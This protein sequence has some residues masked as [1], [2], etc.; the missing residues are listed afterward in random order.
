MQQILKTVKKFLANKSGNFAVTASLIA[1]PL[2]ASGGYAIDYTIMNQQY[3][4]LQDAADA[5]ALA[6]VKELSL[7]GTNE[8][9]IQNVSESYVNTAFS[10]SDMISG[11]N[12]SLQIDTDTD[13]TEGSVTVNLSYTW[14]P[15][16]AHYFDNRVTPI[17]VSAKAG[18]AGKKLTC[19]IGLMQ[20]Q[21]RAKS[22]I[23][24][25]NNAILRAD[26]C[27]V[28]SN[29]VSRYGLRADDRAEMTAGVIC[30]AGGVL[31]LGW[32]A[33][34]QFTPD[35]ITDCPKIPDPLAS[36]VMPGYSG[37]NNQNSVISS[38]ATLS[39]GV[40]CGGLTINGS[41]VANLSPGI[42]VIKDGPLAIRDSA[43]LIGRGI[44]FFLTGSN[45]LINFEAGST[46]DLGAAETGST[47]G[48]LFFEDRG[49]PHSFDFDP[50]RL[51]SL[52]SDVRL[53]RISSNNARNLLGTIYLSKS[54][55]LIDA[56]APVADA[57]AYTAIITGRLWLQQGPILTINADY[58]TTR[59]P[60]PGGLIGAE[61]RLLQ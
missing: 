24:I 12:A 23:H 42:Y 34:A 33:S 7:A 10:N 6:S 31:T 45:S 4:A 40:Y 11:G 29:S 43:S 22:S 3:A 32:R 57:S 59:V 9:L 17:K 56:N 25:D 2:M 37:C 18:L 44:T 5:A 48:M 55:L 54:I 14:A 51:D 13:F 1:V 26:D 38:S 47:A 30:S 21:I 36:R 20:P 19:V 53:H 39:P 52:P 58:T 46:I 27:T 35:P 50:F 28:Y 60:V 15:F 16:L 8:S 41:A 49:V 61:P